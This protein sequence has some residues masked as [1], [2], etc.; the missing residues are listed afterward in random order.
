MTVSEYVQKFQSLSCFAPELVATEERKCRRFEKGLHSIV[1]RMVMVQ[2]KMKFLEV[3]ECA[4]SI[5]IPKEAQRN[6]KVWESR[7]PVGSLS[8]SSSSFGSQRR[9]R[10]ME[11]SQ[12]PSN[13][14][15]FR[16]PSSSGTRG[17]LSR[18][19]PVC[20]KCNQPG[21]IRAQCPHLEK[22][23]YICESISPPLFIETPL[24]GRTPLD[25]ICRA[26][27]LVICDR[28][29]VFDY[30]ILGM[31]GFDLILGMD[32][33]ST[34]HATIDYFKRRV[35]ICPFEGPCFQFFGE[36]PE[37]LK[38]Y[39][40][41]SRE[42]ESIYSLL[43]SLTLDENASVRGELPLVVCDF[44]DV[45]PKELPGLPPERE[46]EFIDLLIGTT[47]ISVPP[48]RFAPAELK[49]LKTQL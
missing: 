9:K 34:F 29:F 38:Q 22:A 15:N 48:Y 8:Y 35:R 18:P 23:C 25:H 41:G 26:Y 40:C 16:V 13:Q 6:S 33:L 31:S 32:W 14:S 17:A 10:Q 46:I 24:G 37:P 28:R 12:Q 27:E 45:F 4:R 5:E 43:A 30:I 11:P 20:Y 36:R 1:R 44:S 19:L 47:L 21:H 2:R 3:V 39:L 42:H 7:Q 49:E